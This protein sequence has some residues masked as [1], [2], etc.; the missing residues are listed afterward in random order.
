MK[1]K[2]SVRRITA[3]VQA[4]LNDLINV[5]YN[6]LPL[7]SRSKAAI[8]FKTIFKESGVEAYL[9]GPENKKQALLQ[10]FTKLYRKHDKLP[11]IIVRKVITNSIEYRRFKRKPL[12]KDEL[13]KLSEVL[14]SLGIDMKSEISKIKIDESIPKIT[15]A[16]EDLIKNL[17]KHDLDIALLVDPLQLFIDGH[18][19]EAVRKAVSVQFSPC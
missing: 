15:I 3:P 1:S 7:T 18:F 19:N 12:T 8:T 17:E 10:G 13:K 5:L 11:K 4:N 6:F 9:V 16:P 14:V 2:A